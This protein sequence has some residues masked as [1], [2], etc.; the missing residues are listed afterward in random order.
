MCV[1][2][3][4]KEMSISL[5]VVDNRKDIMLLLLYAPGKKQVVNEPITGRTRLVKMLFLF[6]KEVLREF[7]KGTKIAEDEFYE[8]FPWNFGPFS[9]DVYD[10]ITFFLLCG[11]IE[12]SNSSDEI[13]PESAN[14][15]SEWESR[16]GADYDDTTNEFVEEEFRLTEKGME[17]S[18]SLWQT[19]SNNQKNLLTTFKSKV[20]NV[21]LRALV[22]YVY[23]VYPDTAERSQI[24]D[25]V[26]GY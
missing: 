26:L 7:K 15:I 19:L 2:L 14:E 20:S 5:R 1:V 21:S 8:F 12:A 24:K 17:F 3:E 13:L 11:F 16:I 23:E 6:R 25:K 10:D 18:E 9:V 4:R 22:R